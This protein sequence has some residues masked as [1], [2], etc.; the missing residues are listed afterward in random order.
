MDDFQQRRRKPVLETRLEK[1]RQSFAKFS[2]EMS[3]RYILHELRS[4]SRRHTLP[5]PELALCQMALTELNSQWELQNKVITK[6]E[7]EKKHITDLF[8]ARI[9]YYVRL[10][11]IS[12]TVVAPE[13]PNNLET[14]KA[15]V[16]KDCEQIQTKLASELGNKRYKEYLL[17]IQ[18]TN[19]DAVDRDCGICRGT[20]AKGVFTPCGHI[21]CSHCIALWMVRHHKCPLCNQGMSPSGLMRFSLGQSQNQKASTQTLQSYEKNHA[22]LKSLKEVQITGS[23]GTKMDTIIRHVKHLQKDDPLVK[24]LVFSQW[25][26]V[27]EYL[28]T[29]LEQNGIKCIKLSYKKARKGEA[30][31]KFRD[32]PSITAFMLNAKSQSAGLT[33]VSA[34]HVFI[35]EPIFSGLDKQAINRVH[36]IGQTQKTFVWRYIIHSTVEDKISK[37]LSSK[38]DSDWEALDATQSNKHAQAESDDIE[39]HLRECLGLHEAEENVI[40]AIQSSTSS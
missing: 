25:E 14:Y 37:I 11:R 26:K 12:D 5:R 32:D 34:T 29:G 23:F 36:R 3:F 33:L 27:L 18:D 35:L 28:E 30:A 24:V 6:L 31:V 38:L 40:Q 2:P 9:Q 7:I 17:S 1:E 8:N 20:I 19:D 10:Q 22:L 16:D 15:Q 39:D 4:L 13:K 21:F